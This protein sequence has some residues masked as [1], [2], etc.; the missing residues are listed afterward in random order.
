MD[1]DDLADQ[2]RPPVAQERH[3]LT[4]LMAG[5]GHAQRFGAGGYRIAGKDR[6][7]LALQRIGIEPKLDRQRPVELD[8]PRLGNRCR[9]SRRMKML[10]QPGIAVVEGN[11]GGRCRL[12]AHG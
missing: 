6:R 1:I 11:G 7:P 4:K 10:R 8:Q 3:E 2:D 5:I 12:F 9:N